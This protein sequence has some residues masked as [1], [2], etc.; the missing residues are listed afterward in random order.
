MSACGSPLVPTYIEGYPALPWKCSSKILECISTNH[1]P[2]QGIEKERKGDED[3]PGVGTNTSKSQYRRV[4]HY[5][6]APAPTLWDLTSQRPMAQPPTTLSFADRCSHI[7]K[8]IFLFRH[9]SFKVA[10]PMSQSC[11]NHSLVCAMYW[12]HVRKQDAL[13]AH[14]SDHERSST[15]Q[16]F[17]RG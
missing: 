2:F 3:V 7:S 14:L 4:S 10:I 1:F 17:S 9:S 13:A 11:R 5:C 6:N 8:Y 12:H 16:R 15:C